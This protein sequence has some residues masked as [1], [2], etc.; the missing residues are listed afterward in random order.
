MRIGR[1]AY[2]LA[3]L[4]ERWNLSAADIRSLV[5]RGILAL[6]VRIVAQPALLS[7]QDETMEGEIVWCQRQSKS[8]PKGRAKCCHFWVGMIAA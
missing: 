8:E 2:E 4:A 7:V 3:E 6:S 1:D 5:G